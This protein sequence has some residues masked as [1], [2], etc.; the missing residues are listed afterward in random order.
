MQLLFFVSMTESNESVELKV[1][2]GSEEFAH[3]GELSRKEKIIYALGQLPGTFYGSFMGQIQAFYYG[4][5]G[6]AYKWILITQ[7]VYAVWNA[8]NDPI[9]G[10]LQDRTNTKSGRY[11]PWI[12]W[13]SP[14]FTIAF[15]VVFLPP[16]EWRFKTGGEQYQV[17][18]AMWYLVSQILYDTG[19]TIVF[20]AH[21]ALAPQMTM[22]EMERREIQIY[23]SIMGVIGMASS[24]IIPLIF[25]TNPDPDKI[26]LFQIAVI[27]FALVGLVPWYLIVKNVKENPEF[28]PPKENQVSFIENVKYVF[29]NPSG[30]IYMVYDGVSVGIL[31]TVV[32]AVPFVFSWIFGMHGEFNE[33]WGIMD[34]I[35]Y[36]VPILICFLIGLWIELKIPEPKEKGGFG[37]D[38]KFALMYSMI[39]EGIGFLIAFFGVYTST[40]LSNNEFVVPN[41]LWMVS[42]GMSI[43]MLGFS[44]DFIYH[45][46][47]RADTIDW[48][49]LSTGERR[50]SVY[51]GVGCLISKPMISV[52][53]II[54][55][56][57]MSE[58]GL[59]P[60]SPNDPTDSALIVENGFRNAAIGVAWGAFLFTAILAFIGIAFWKFYPLDKETLK[61]MRADLA[62]LHDKKRS[63]R[64]TNKKPIEGSNQESSAES[65]ES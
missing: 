26:R 56:Y 35:W 4:W 6:L 3:E 62:K 51:A 57:F 32:A 44:G 42:L 13:V 31:N 34:I 25:L 23:S 52:A 50:E 19:F 9:F 1:D 61:V 59:V 5:M 48:D 63:E 37:K 58:Y 55:P 29:K 24:S 43:A 21:V 38:V 39:C 27:V 8:V 7:I 28:I 2:S 14:F 12:K 46:V 53:L 11:I 47:M 22:D 45:N 36:V 40:N 54:V 33:N 64:L 18:L 20:L 60:A 49:E 17:L 10:V 15:M 30:R 41:R 16:Q 65:T